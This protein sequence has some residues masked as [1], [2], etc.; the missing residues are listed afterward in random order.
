MLD[1]QELSKIMYNFDDEKEKPT[2]AD[3]I[4]ASKAVKDDSLENYHPCSSGGNN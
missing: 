4:T 1:D 3:M 2:D